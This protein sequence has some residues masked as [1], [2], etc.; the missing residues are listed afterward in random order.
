MAW[1]FDASTDMIVG[2]G[3]TG[4]THTV[5]FW[6]TRRVDRGA[7]SNP[8]MLRAGAG[9][10]GADVMGIGSDA[11]GD[12]IVLFDSV[13]NSITG[14]AMVTDRWE[15]YAAFLNGTAWTF[16]TGTLPSNLASAAGTVTRN[17]ATSPGSFTLSSGD[18]FNG[19]LAN[20]KIFNRV[21]TLADAQA[22]LSTYDQVSATNLIRRH[23]MRTVTMVPDSGSAGTN[24]TAGSTA[25][26]LEAGPAFLDPPAMPPGRMLLAGV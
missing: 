19:A 18:W 12:N 16:Y 5:L 6:L 1:R 26:S 20:L 9:A 11:G 24:L 14:Q 8:F 23:T 25:V 13:Y 4:T 21:L 15:C 10:T 2:P 17:A 3:W 7:Y 22:E